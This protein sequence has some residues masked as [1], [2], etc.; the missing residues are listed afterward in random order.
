[1]IASIFLII[2]AQTL[3]PTIE[4]TMTTQVEEEVKAAPT[5][6]QIDAL[7]REYASAA[8]AVAFATGMLGTANKARSEIKARL[9]VM[10]ESF[11]FRHTEKSKRLLG[12]HSTATTTTGTYV[13]VDAA[14]VTAFKA[15]LDKTYEPDLVARFFSAHVSYSLVDGPADVLRT[16]DLGK[17]A[18]AKIAS[19]VAL[20]FNISTK[21]PSLKVE[22]ITPEKPERAHT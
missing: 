10:V 14:A 9:I 21:S 22:T 8:A 18:A 5:P 15:Y 4:A 3:A 17:R 13:S 7:V 6:A 11:G 12:A 1:V 19:M 2:C 16:M 20:C